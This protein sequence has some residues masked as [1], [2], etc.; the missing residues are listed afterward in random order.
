MGNGP[1]NQQSRSSEMI[2][3]SRKPL[4]VKQKTKNKKLLVFSTDILSE[5]LAPLL[6][7]FLE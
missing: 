3:I 2:P 1:D 7:E 4:K 6:V 5:W